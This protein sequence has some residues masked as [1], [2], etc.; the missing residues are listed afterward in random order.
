MIKPTAP[1]QWR[2]SSYCGTGACVE[3]A[4]VAGTY[5]VRDGKDPNGEVLSFSAAEWADFVS[6]VKAG[7]FD[8]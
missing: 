6:A 8:V 3:L 4:E 5:L 2:R 1:A 7:R